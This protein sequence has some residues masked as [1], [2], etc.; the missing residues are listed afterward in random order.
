MLS[1]VADEGDP[2]EDAEPPDHAAALPGDQRGM[3]IHDEKTD[4]EPADDSVA[5]SP[6]AYIEPG[7]GFL[8]NPRR[9]N[10]AIS[11]AKFGLAIVCDPRA[12]INDSHW[13][14][15]VAYAACLGGMVI[16]SD[17]EMP[18]PGS[19]PETVIA[20]S[21]VES[22]A[23]GSSAEAPIQAGTAAENSAGT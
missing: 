5:V 4:D 1:P 3:S 22:H 17:M 9:T 18:L 20:S 10:V 8:V 7:L 16:P 11:R 12:V 2:S 19:D 21:A 15:C 14:A 13:A 6:P 23:D